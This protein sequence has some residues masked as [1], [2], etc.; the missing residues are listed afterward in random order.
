MRMHGGS[1]NPAVVR[2]FNESRAL[3]ASQRVLRQALSEVAMKTPNLN[4]SN[5]HL[6]HVERPHFSMPHSK[7]GTH[8]KASRLHALGNIWALLL[9]AIVVTAV[10]AGF[11]MAGSAS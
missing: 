2:P 9:A 7:E 5:L 1:G 11:W 6:P 4:L 10:A 8:F 3:F